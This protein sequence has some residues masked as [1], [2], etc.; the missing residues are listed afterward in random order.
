MYDNVF[1]RLYYLYDM[2]K[3]GVGSIQYVRRVNIRNMT[4][5]QF[6]TLLQGYE[7]MQQIK[8]K[9]GYNFMAGLHGVP[10]DWCIHWQEQRRVD[11]GGRY[12]LPWHRAYLYMFEQ[13]LKDFTDGSVGVPWWDW[14]SKRSR[15]EGIPEEFST[16]QF[17]GKNNPLFKADIKVSFPEI[18]KKTYRRTNNTPDELIFRLDRFTG[19][20]PTTTDNPSKTPGGNL[21]ER[22]LALSDFGDFSDALQG[23]HGA[24][25]VYVGGSMGSA[26]FAAYDPI[27]WSHHS[28]VDRIWRLWQLKNGDSTVPDK[29]LDYALDPF[30]F[31]VRQV[32][33]VHNLGYD[34]AG[35]EIIV[36]G[37]K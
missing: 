14:S 36:E 19:G 23:I 2:S 32:L 35:I 3:D 13:S 30:P 18:N 24:I 15:Q 1:I 9:R 7:K 28:M 26:D 4:K 34:Y 16:E 22:L 37:N 12:F 20:L 11:L 27:F 33:N 10:F 31:T 21:I 5:P 25:H 6:S 17:N 29:I 8:D